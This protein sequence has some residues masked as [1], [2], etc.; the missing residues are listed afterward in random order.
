MSSDHSGFKLGIKNRKM[1]GKS[2]N[3][4][5]VL[6]NPRVKEEIRR[7]KKMYF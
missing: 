7:E 3:V 2:S 5:E 6:N 4:W 1:S